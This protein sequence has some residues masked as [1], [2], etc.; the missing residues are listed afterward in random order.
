MSEGLCAGIPGARHAL[1]DRA[2]HAPSMGQPEA[3]N[4]VVLPFLHDVATKETP[5][6]QSKAVIA[7][8]AGCREMGVQAGR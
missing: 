5:A 6:V 3:F 7:T 4:R 1:I 2:G 8:V